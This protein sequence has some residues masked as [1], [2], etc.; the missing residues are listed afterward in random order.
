MTFKNWPTFEQITCAYRACRLGKRASVHQTRF[1]AHLGKNLIELHGELLSGKYKP[2]PVVCFVV[3]HPR[4]REIFAAHFRDRIVHHLVVGELTP[5]WERK[6]IHSSFACRNGRGTHGALKYLQNAVRKI[7]QG[8]IRPVYALQLD[9]ASFFV[10]IHRPTLCHLLTKNL[11][12]ERLKRLVEILY[13]T[14]SR[15]NALLKGPKHLF[16]LIPKEKSWFGQSKDQGI[17]I[18]NLISQFGANVYLTGLDHLIQ[19]KLKPNA[20]LRYMDDLIL[21]D[22]DPERLRPFEKIIDDWLKA[23]RRQSLNP[24]KTRLSRMSEGIDYLGY[25]CRQGDSPREP[26]QFFL[27]PQKKWEWIQTLKDLAALDFQSTEKPHP[28]SHHL[29]S[30]KVNQTLSRANSR[31]GYMKHAESFRLRKDS[32]DRL[33]RDTNRGR[34]LPDAPPLELG[35]PWVPLKTRRDYLAIRRR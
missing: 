1:E 22:T 23:H 21:L 32:I 4:P 35:D 11:K 9:L 2:S 14:D 13:L 33:L 18:G 31:L 15:P 26:V 8:G 19:R 27:E 7:S 24:A 34:G 25:R 29:E 16:D 12:N 17:P 5:M 10:T 28:L 6:F 20:Y 30:E 3:T